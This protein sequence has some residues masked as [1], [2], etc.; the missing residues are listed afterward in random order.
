VRGCRRCATRLASLE[1]T[2]IVHADAMKVLGAVRGLPSAATCAAEPGEDSSARRPNSCRVRDPGRR[3]RQTADTREAGVG[4][5]GTM[6]N[7]LS[8]LRPG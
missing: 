3:G 2:F 7:L 6:T 5:T 8:H 1:V 4:F